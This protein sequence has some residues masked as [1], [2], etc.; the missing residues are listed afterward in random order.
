M[1][2][3]DQMTAQADQYGNELRNTKGEISELKR[4]IARLENEI[5][6]AK[7]QVSERFRGYLT[8]WKPTGNWTCR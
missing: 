1:H 7:A 5:L 4:M 8:G 2:Q 6:S 3:F